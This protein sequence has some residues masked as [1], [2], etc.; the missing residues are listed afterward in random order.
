MRDLNKGN[1]AKEKILKETGAGE[2]MVEVWELDM[3][4]FG[5]VR[6]FAERVNKTL[7]RLDGAVLNA[8]IHAGGWEVTVDGWERT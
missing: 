5:S 4:D 3:A 8:G 2:A 1:A 6:R 7:E